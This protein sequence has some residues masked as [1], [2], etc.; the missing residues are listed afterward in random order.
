MDIRDS[1]K[2][3]IEKL[4][5]EIQ[6]NKIPDPFEPPTLDNVTHI[7]KCLKSFKW[8]DI[9]CICKKVIIYRQLI[10]FQMLGQIM[11]LCC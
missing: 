1:L 6:D 7:I 2:L 4:L 3:K 8:N 10:E 11:A 5:E 9:N